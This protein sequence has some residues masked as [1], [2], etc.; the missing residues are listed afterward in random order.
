MLNQLSLIISL[1]FLLSTTKSID[2]S[3]NFLDATFVSWNKDTF[4]SLESHIK[5]KSQNLQDSLYK[6]RILTLTGYWGIE[7]L[8][9]INRQSIRYSFLSKLFPDRKNENIDFYVVEANRSGESVQLRNFFFYIDSSHTAY[10][11]FY[12]FLKN[13]WDRVGEAKI[14]NF[15]VA[16]SL[17][18]DFVEFGKGNNDDDVIVTKFHQGK[19]KESEYY[20]ISTLSKQS[21]VMDVLDT[22]TIKNLSYIK[23]RQAN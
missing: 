14:N 6:N 1:S 23:K 18:S 4:K 21:R 5:L 20:L 19:I 11:E 22:F 3:G 16:E 7:N 13:R 12:V 2:S 9:D 15:Y 17:K 10:I 8:E